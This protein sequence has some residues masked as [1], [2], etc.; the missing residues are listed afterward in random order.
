LHERGVDLNNT[1]IVST[2]IFLEK[3]NCAKCQR[4][5]SCLFHSFH[6]ARKG[7]KKKEEK[8]VSHTRKFERP[9]RASA[10]GFRFQNRTRRFAITAIGARV[11]HS[12]LLAKK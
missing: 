5:V 8:K 10:F 7:L 2:Q 4:V 1:V 6:F 12:L 3:S 9:S 11:H